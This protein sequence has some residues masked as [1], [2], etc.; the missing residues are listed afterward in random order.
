MKTFST[1]WSHQHSL[2]NQIHKIIHFMCKWKKAVSPP[3][4]YSR[5]HTGKNWSAYFFRN[6]LLTSHLK[7]MVT[8][9]CLFVAKTFL[10]VTDFCLL[11][12]GA[13]LCFCQW[14]TSSVSRNDERHGWFLELLRNLG[15]FGPQFHTK[16]LPFIYNFT[17]MMLWVRH[18]PVEGISLQFSTPQ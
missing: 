18:Y 15:T 17:V 7:L 8:D 12:P 5:C 13:N 6:R 2:H 9:F 10:F 16:T 1:V 4:G 3:G 14:D 11:S